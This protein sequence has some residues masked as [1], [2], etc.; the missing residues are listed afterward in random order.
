MN[1]APKK[2]YLPFIK[3]VKLAYKNRK[4]YSRT[5]R[6]QEDKKMGKNVFVCHL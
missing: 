1:F 6:Q 4:E 2:L 3:L 5:D